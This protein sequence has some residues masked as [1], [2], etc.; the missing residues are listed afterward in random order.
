[1][2]NLKKVLALGLALVMILGMFTIA[3]A[4]ETKK[5]AQEFPDWASVEN[6]DA[7]SLMVDLGVINGLP[8]GTYAPAQT[9]DRAS[10][11]KMVFFVLTGENDAKVYESDYP[12][13][14]DIANTWAQG[15][16]EYLYSIE[17]VSGDTDGNYKPTDSISVVAAAKTM[18]TGLGYNSKIEGYENNANWATNIMN[19]A[20]AIGLMNGIS[21]KQ[22]DNITRDA[23]AQMVCN[24]LEAKT[25]TAKYTLNFMT[26]ERVPSGE[27]DEGVALAEKAFDIRKFDFNVE[28]V[29]K[30]GNAVFTNG[31]KGDVKASLSDVGK[32]VSV[33]CK[34][35]SKTGN[36]T[37]A[38]STSVVG[39]GKA[40][41]KTIAGGIS[42]WSK[43]FNSDNKD[44][45]NYVGDAKTSVIVITNGTKAASNMTVTATTGAVTNA[46][47]TT[48]AGDVVEFYTDDEGL[49]ES[50]RIYNYTVAKLS[51]DPASKTDKDGNTTVDLKVAGLNS[52]IPVGQITGD[53]SSMKKDDVVLYYAK[54]T[55]ADAL[56]T[57][58]KAEI[59]TGK[60]TNKNAKTGKITVNGTQYGES[61]KTL[62]SLTAFDNLAPNKD[63]EYDFYMDKNGTIIG[64]TLVEGEVETKVAY[65]IRAGKVQPTG[66]GLSEAADPYLEV[67]LLFTDAT[68]QIV[69]VVKVGEKETKDMNEAELTAAETTLKAGDMVD[70]S[71]DDDGNYAVTAKN[72]SAIAAG[73]ISA[74][75]AFSAGTTTLTANTSTLFLVKKGTGDDAEYLVYTSYKNVPAMDSAT[76]KAIKEDG[77]VTYAY[78]E[79]EAFA[80]EGS[81]G[82][83][84]INDAADYSEGTTEN[85][86]TYYNV[87][88]AK[89][90]VLESMDINVKSGNV[91]PVSKTFYKIKSTTDGVSVLEAAG[92]TAVTLDSIGGGVVVA[93]TSY[94]YDEASVCVL[95]DTTDEDLS[96]SAFDPDN[97]S[98]EDEKT[99][100]AVI[101]ASDGVIEYIYVIAA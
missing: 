89:G 70:Y 77:F 71:I 75:P 93:D 79:T 17:C 92:K 16:I 49:V 78:L 56:V 1:M 19:K 63:N 76:G 39:A 58:E 55:G 3:S 42:D 64:A 69:K 54:G 24:A 5:T 50:V 85:V 88:D 74:K 22:N 12:A 68:T 11:A 65:A 80:G 90:E 25:Q 96:A 60:I 59:V 81:D 73:A 53:W 15:F 83:I 45:D 95:I 7:V 33:W 13:L 38:V 43:V 27:Y 41:A 2:K 98:K 87:V 26:G 44:E 62:A 52:K 28:D 23:A 31:P 86:R 6:K 91:T 100:T 18:L 20:K 10:W 40:P 29:D 21:L 8:D 82:L 57:I 84:Y 61:G 35:D 48:V 67:E 14:K 30:N 101:L 97:F 37:D 94:S 34:F 32:S 47:A 51:A 4:A 99:Y 36:A 72:A 46:P 66:S 9:I